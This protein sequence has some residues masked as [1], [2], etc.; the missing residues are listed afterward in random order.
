MII[1]QLFEYDITKINNFTKLEIYLMKLPLHQIYLDNGSLIN[2]QKFNEC[3]Y[4]IIFNNGNDK[5][6]YIKNIQ[7]IST[8]DK[9]KEKNQVFFN[10]TPNIYGFNS[11]SYNIKLINIINKTYFNFV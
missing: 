5:A 3:D 4:N 9:L 6:V 2:G 8:W 7:T 10:N 1:E 11:E